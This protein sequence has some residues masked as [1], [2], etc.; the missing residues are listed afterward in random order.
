MAKDDIDAQLPLPPATFHILMALTDDDTPRLRHHPGRRGAHRRRAPAQRGNALPIHPTHARRRP[1][2][3]SSASARRPRSTMNGV[4]TTRSRRSVRAVARAELRRLTQ[5]VRLAKARG[6]TPERRDAFLSRAAPP[7]SVVVPRRVRRRA[8]GDVRGAAPAREAPSSP[9]FAAI[10]DVV[11][12]AIAAHWDILR[13]DLRHAARTLRRSPGF[14]ITAVLVVALGVG[15]NT[16]AFS[17]A[18]FVLSARS[19]F[20][21]RNSSSVVRETTP[22]YSNGALA[23]ELQ[24]LE[25]RREVVLRDE[26]VLPDRGQSHRLGRATPRPD[27]AG[28]L[29]PVQHARRQALRWAGRSVA[30]DTVAGHALIVSY[31]LWQTQFGADPSSIGKQVH[32]DGTRSPSSASCRRAFHFPSRDV[33]LWQ[34]MPFTAE[35]LVPREQQLPHRSSRACARRD[36]RAGARRIARDRASASSSSSRQENEKT[37]AEATRLSDQLSDAFAAVV[38]RA[39]RRV[40]LHS[41]A[42]LRESRQP[43]ARSRRQPRTRAGCA[44]RARRG[45]RA[46]RA[47]DRHREPRARR[48]IG[49][50]V[51]VLVAIA[52]V[53]ALSRLVPDSLPIAAAAE[54]R[55]SRPRVRRRR[56]WCSP[57]S[58]SASSRRCTPA[59]AKS[60]AAVAR[61]RAFRRW[62]ETARAIGPG[63]RRSDGVGRLLI[64]S[65]LLVR[66]MWRLQVDR[67]GLSFGE[68]ADAAHRTAMAEVRRS[69]DARHRSIRK[70]ST[71]S[72]RL[73][74][75]KSAAYISFLPMVMRGGIWP[76]DHERQRGGSRSA[77][78]S[79]SLRFVTPQFFATL[80]IPLLQGRDIAET[81]EQARRT[82]R[83]SASRSPSATGRTRPALGKAFQVRDARSHGRR[84]RRRHARAWSRAVE[85]AAGL[86]PVSSR[87]TRQR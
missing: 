69:R 39:L 35:E 75:V 11:P 44:R 8:R 15:A 53:P 38:A 2:R 7:V 9:C 73:P 83:S 12:N 72:A 52:A 25:R 3:R 49:G 20:P 43:A 16:A 36:A 81:D 37:G 40:A 1:H 60:L 33:Q 50:V 34:S 55:S 28:E 71:T 62:R 82:S 46:H 56:W 80:R 51:G 6:L 30:S 13:A 66:A 10:A 78:N 58:R 63:R 87:S 26:R 57:D 61:R 48:S 29:G 21:N 76:V 14:A 84:R 22:G 27:D 74:G 79:A 65:G 45:T 59:G 54:R 5:L 31:D 86:R 18:D 41:P 32:L 19:R 24:G 17:V 68:R 47:P 23:R 70:Y 77:A 67:S 42:R 64:S 4:A 85:R